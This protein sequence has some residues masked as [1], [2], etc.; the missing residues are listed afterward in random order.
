MEQTNGGVTSR[1]ICIPE[2]WCGAQGRVRPD[3]LVAAMQDAAGLHLVRCGISLDALAAQGC[4]LVLLWTELRLQRLPAAGE[5]VEL[6]VWFGREKHGMHSAHY[7][8]LGADGQAAA[9]MASWWVAIDRESRTLAPSGQIMGR[10]PRY[11]EEGE[12]FAPMQE[13]FP[14]S[15]PCRAERTVQR[16]EIDYNGHMNNAHYIRWACELPE[17]A[18]PRCR[19]TRLWAE[20]SVELLEGQRAAMQYGREGETLYVLGSRDG[21][22]SFRL[23]MEYTREE[24]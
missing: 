18:P 1:S 14:H 8:C 16:R 20:Y 23:K 24:P 15:L 17:G 9:A 12:L 7:Q 3:A 11:S 10:L 6:R 2:A 19:L 13:S 4:L 22:A 21:E 5:T